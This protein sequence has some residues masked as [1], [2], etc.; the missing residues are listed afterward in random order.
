[1]KTENPHLDTGCPGKEYFERRDKEFKPLIKEA[2]GEALGDVPGHLRKAAVNR[3][4]LVWLTAGMFVFG[5]LLIA[6]L[7]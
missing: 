5:V 2:V 7:T 1:M 6:H 3:M 4:W